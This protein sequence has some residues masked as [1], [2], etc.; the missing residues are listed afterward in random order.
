MIP[1]TGMTASWLLLLLVVP[2]S[3]QTKSRPPKEFKAPNSIVYTIR[4]IL[5]RDEGCAKDYA[6][7]IFSFSGIEQRKLLAELFAY[8]CAE[9]L[10]DA[11]HGYILETKALIDC[12][13]EL[14]KALNGGCLMSRIELIPI[15]DFAPFPYESEFSPTKIVNDKSKYGW[16]LRRDLMSRADLM[17]LHPNGAKDTR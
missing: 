12:G 3:A 17:R 11:Y 14:H 15:D 4:P 6:K 2:A 10:T 16:V 9:Q 5:A 8:K 1:R 7:A 13:D